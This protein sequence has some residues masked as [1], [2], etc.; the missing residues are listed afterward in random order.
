MVEICKKSV[1]RE[2]QEI[3]SHP[4]LVELSKG[5]LPREKFDYYLAQDYIYL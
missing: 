1:A 4:F 5:I 2:W 3:L